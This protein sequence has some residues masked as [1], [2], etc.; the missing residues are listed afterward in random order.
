MPTSAEMFICSQDRQS[1]I[2]RALTASGE[3]SQRQGQLRA[4]NTLPTV[5]L[6]AACKHINIYTDKF[7]ISMFDKT[8]SAFNCYQDHSQKT[9][10]AAIVAD[11]LNTAA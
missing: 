10:N 3:Y 9:N 1:T 7:N 8:K 4:D 2:D 5:L 6:Q 11:L